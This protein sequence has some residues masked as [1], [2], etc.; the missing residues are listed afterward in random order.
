[1]MKPTDLRVGNWVKDENGFGYVV[2]ITFAPSQIEPYRAI[3][4]NRRSIVGSSFRELEPIPLTP[5]ILK[6]CKFDMHARSVSFGDSGYDPKYFYYI[7]DG[8]DE[9]K[10][11]TYRHGFVL[12]DFRDGY[13]Y[14]ANQRRTKGIKIEYLH[15]L[16]NLYFALTGEELFIEL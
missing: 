6:K 10:Q 15:Q 8:I 7:L 4:S 11:R 16:Q 12:G 1:M 5:E 3:L 14:Q 9:F 2:A 13:Y